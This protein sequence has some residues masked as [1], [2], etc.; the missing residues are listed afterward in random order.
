MV[1][2]GFTRDYCTSYL[3]VITISYFPLFLHI[4]NYLANICVSIIILA[5]TYSMQYIYFTCQSNDF[6]FNHDKNECGSSLHFDVIKIAKR[7]F[8]MYFQYIQ[9]LSFSLAFNFPD[10]CDKLI[11]NN[12][13][14]DDSFCN[15]LL[16]MAREKE[17]VSEN[18]F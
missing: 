6:I 17:V 9:Q 14:Y 5:F 4:Y 8:F 10:I 18:R 11:Y 16:M 2:R 12:D 13:L 3:L 7:F 15:Y 1:L